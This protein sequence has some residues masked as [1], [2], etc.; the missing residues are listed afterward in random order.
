MF[1][2]RIFLKLT[3]WL[4]VA[5]F[6]FSVLMPGRVLGDNGNCP[7]EKENL[8]PTIE[9][10]RLSIKM[11]DL[12]CAEKELLAFLALPNISNEEKATAHILLGQ[13]YF[14]LADKE[15]KREKALN[16]FK[17]GFRAYPE[18]TGKLEINRTELQTLLEEA[19]Q[20][21]EMEIETQR[22]DT[23]FVAKG[24]PWYK[25]WWVIG[26]GVGV[27]ALTAVLLAGGG[28]DDNGGSTVDTIPDFPNPPSKK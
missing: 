10:A 5:F 6:S 21:V 22:S 4:I 1:K 23:L 28:G 18:W 9:S 15:R 3:A 14:E 8:A 11:P 24:K 17:E 7:Y 16:E 26:S 2:N 12:R 20:R 13:V 27:V 19:R 25:K